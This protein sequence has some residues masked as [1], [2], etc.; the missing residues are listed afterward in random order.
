MTIDQKVNCREAARQHSM[1]NGY[2]I[3]CIDWD[4]NLFYTGSKLVG[5]VITRGAKRIVA[6]FKNG[7]A[8]H[9]YS[10]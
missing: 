6:C 7:I 5:K 4:G 8:V 2:A 9:R 3:V 10:F 1:V